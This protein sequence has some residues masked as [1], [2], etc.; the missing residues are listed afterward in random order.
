MHDT[1][2]NGNEVNF[3]IFNHEDDS[4]ERFKNKGKPLAFQC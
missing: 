1:S 3:L 2:A 4:E